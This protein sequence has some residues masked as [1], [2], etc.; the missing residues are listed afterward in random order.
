MADELAVD[1]KALIFATLADVYLS[2]GMVDE[3]I[4]IL[5]DGL[6]RNPGYTLA[7]IILGRAYYLKGEPEEALRL[8]LGI[9][10]QVKDSESAN[11][12]IAHSYRRIGDTEKAARFYQEVLRINPGNTDAQKEIGGFGPAATDAIKPLGVAPVERM[13]VAVPIDEDKAPSKPEPTIVPPA[14]VKPEALPEGVGAPPE[15]TTLESIG[16]LPVEEEP[17]LARTPTEVPPPSESI[18]VAAGVPPPPVSAPEVIAPAEPISAPSPDSGMPVLPEI[19]LESSTASV[20]E[21]GGTSPLDRLTGPVQRL[22][23]MKSVRGVLICSRDGLLIQSYFPGRADVEEICALIAAVYNEADDSFKFLKE[24]SLE[25]CLIE[26]PGETVCVITAGES[27]L[28]IITETEA[29]PGLIFVYAR[30]V[31]EE[32]REILG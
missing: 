28:C 29:K 12:Y 3:A 10:E 21:E 19:G 26:R 4:S 17:T 31:I 27:L 25:R 24:G 15:T 9:Y 7:K 2:S 5:K 16:A 11:L 18:P 13:V 1:S 23:D 22:L 6:A 14:P 32:I 8:L 30:K 20:K